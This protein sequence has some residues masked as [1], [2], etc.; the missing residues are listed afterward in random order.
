MEENTIFANRY[1][2]QKRIG[3]GGFSEVW[4]AVDQMADDTVVAIKIYAPDR[5]MDAQ[6]LKQFRRE[7]AVVLNL[8]H[9]NLLTARYFDVWE[10]RP[11]LVMPLIEGGSLYDKLEREGN[12]TEKQTAELIRQVADGLQH[13]HAH[14]IL[15]QDI[16]P[17]NI[18][19]GKNETYLLMDFGISMRIR[20]TL[21]KQTGMMKAMTV[22]YAPPERFSAKPKQIPAGDIFSLGVLIYEMMTGDVPWMGNG[23]VSLQTGAAVP[24]LPED[25]SKPFRRL[26]ASMMALKPEDRP[27]PET[28]VEA[29]SHYI[30]TGD[31]PD[32]ENAG[33]GAGRTSRGRE[34]QIFDSAG[35]A[36]VASPHTEDSEESPEEKPATPDS[37]GG[38]AT[39]PMSSEVAAAALGTDPKSGA[40]DKQDG[41]KTQI[42]RA[43]D[44]SAGDSGGAGSQTSS[45]ESKSGGAG[46]WIIAAAILLLLSGGGYFGYNQYTQNIAEREAQILALLDEAATEVEAGELDAALLKYE[47]V[48]DLDSSN[49][50]ALSQISNVR[51][52]ITQR[53]AEEEAER[54]RLL[55]EATAARARE[56]EMARELERIRLEEEARRN[57]TGTVT[58]ASTG[59]Q[60][61]GASIS[62]QGSNVRSASNARGGYAI[63][64][65]DANAVL[66]ISYMGYESQ[67]ISPNGRTQINVEL[68]PEAVVPDLS[69]SPLNGTVS[70]TGGFEPDPWTGNYTISAGNVDL[71]QFEGAGYVTQ[72]PTLNL[73]YRSSG[74][75]L[76]IGAE[77]STDLIILIHK[78]DGELVINDDFSGTNPRIEMEN[79][80]SGLYNIWVGTFTQTNASAQVYITEIAADN[81]DSQTNT[82]GD[83]NG[84]DPSLS[85]QYGSA[86][87]SAGFLP[88]PHTQNILAGGS[89]NLSDYGFTGYVAQT[90]DYELNFSAG[91]SADPL[92]IK[93]GEAEG[94]TVILVR[95]PG[96]QWEY[97]DD[98]EDMNAGIRF[99]NPESGRYKIWIGS[100]NN[101]FV[102]STLHITEL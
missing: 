97:N 65:P 2:L 88:D 90:P 6:G 56:E 81:D 3:M 101:E 46:K 79:P 66:E 71:S 39:Q 58:D 52:L 27:T 49:E 99:D 92:I 44:A 94:D 77:S 80:Q 25:L 76:I 67:E 42:G 4:S 91:S 82:L 17:D 34:T 102:Q 86:E 23:G 100:Y 21:R 50:T 29:A 37:K 63:T 28:L 61:A 45:S 10:G 83:G 78:P 40:A 70:L 96:G 31:W 7:Y 18:L 12:F 11:Y 87:L 16:K 55:D 53:E 8:N 13:L 36:A 89:V 84:P 95:T 35:F 30:R 19:I 51:Q 14:D 48:L 72:A 33:Q 69:L 43:S 74:Y 62:V 22:A 60:L 47:S 24:E 73:N 98:F 54:Q 15:H 75:N 85:S 93:V 9:S 20:S 64:L 1:K 59:E 26:V 5:G 32:A 41:K 57:I 38:R 68:Q